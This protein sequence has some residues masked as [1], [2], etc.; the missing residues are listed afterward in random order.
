MKYS[1]Y[2]FWEVDIVVVCGYFDNNG[3]KSV[4]M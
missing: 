4:I 1:L 3:D 2:R